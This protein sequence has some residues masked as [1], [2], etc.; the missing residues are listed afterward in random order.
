MFEG[1]KAPY[2]GVGNLGNLRGV[3]ARRS[4]IMNKLLNTKS[5]GDNNTK[6]KV[7]KE[8]TEQTNK[9]MEAIQKNKK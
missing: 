3:K 8:E 6:A 4:F 7:D 5:D 2:L 1:N 9:L